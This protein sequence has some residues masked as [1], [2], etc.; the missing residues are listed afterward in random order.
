[1]TE[2]LGIAPLQPDRVRPSTLANRE[3]SRRWRE[4]HPDDPAHFCDRPYHR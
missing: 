4:E 3:H 1:M 2:S